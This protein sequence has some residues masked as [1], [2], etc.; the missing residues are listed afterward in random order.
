[1]WAPVKEKSPKRERKEMDVSLQI[2]KNKRNTVEGHLE[3]Q[4]VEVDP[5]DPL[6]NEMEN[7]RGNDDAMDVVI[8]S[9]MEIR[10]LILMEI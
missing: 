9:I 8:D 3:L 5:E 2:Q 7:M 10:T 1:M 6:M 4:I